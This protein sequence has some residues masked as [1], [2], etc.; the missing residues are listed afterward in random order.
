ME[1]FGQS[2]ILACVA[3]FLVW[4]VIRRDLARHAGSSASLDEI[5]RLR[6]VVEEL[7]TALEGR[8]DVAERRLSKAI[9]EA[10]AVQALLDRTLSGVGSQIVRGENVPARPKPGQDLLESDVAPIGSG[11]QSTLEEPIA[12]EVTAVGVV[13]QQQSSADE[14]S[15]S[16]QDVEP[17]AVPAEPPEDSRYAAIYALVASGVTD[18]I[19]IARRTGL[20][21]GE[22]E[23][24]MGLHARNVL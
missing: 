23:L 12:D 10:Q 17:G 15:E 1:A 19:E 11:G 18:S 14:E 3:G 5:D 21:R 6:K 2:L 4:W 22:V 24:H 20:G 13:P 8:A 9:A 7:S 16:A